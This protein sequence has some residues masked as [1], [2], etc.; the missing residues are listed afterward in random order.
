[1]TKKIKDVDAFYSD[2]YREIMGTGIISRVWG[3]I[4]SQMER[5]FSG[6]SYPNILEIGAGN[7][8]HIP[9]VACNYE[10]YL[11]TDI[12]IENLSNI[13]KI[14]SRVKLQVEDAQKLTLQDDSFDRVIVTCLLAHLDK[15]EE[16]VAELH[17]VVRKHSGYVTIYLPCEPGIF[18]RLIR[19]FSTHLK[20]R[21]RGVE[22]ISRIH[23]LEH[24]NYYLALDSLITNE[25]NGSRI[26]KRFY[27]FRYLSWNLNLYRIYQISNIH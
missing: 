24:R 18:L 15:P 7:G 3:I 13:Q 16:A 8:E 17:R 6:G 1:M 14:E 9:F 4:H 23:Y 10:S 2:H 5:P 21:K 27:P 26:K 12:R 20:A 22:D 25:F 19:N 11:A